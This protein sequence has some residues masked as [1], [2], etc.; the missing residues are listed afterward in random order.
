VERNVSANWHNIFCV[1]CTL[2]IDRQSRGPREAIRY[3]NHF[4]R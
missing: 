2:I 3:L 1:S 4:P